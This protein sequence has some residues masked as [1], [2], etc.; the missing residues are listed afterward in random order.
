MGDRVS[1]GFQFLEDDVTGDPTGLRRARDG[2]TFPLAPVSGAWKRTEAVVKHIGSS[3]HTGVCF[4][5]VTGG[6]ANGGASALVLSITVKMEMETDFS[7]VRLV[8]IN[9]AQTA[10]NANIAVVGV[11]ETHAIDTSANMGTPVIG[12]TAYAQLAPAGTVSGWR[13]VT[14]GGASSVNVAAAPTAQQFA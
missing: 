4:N 1:T 10:I 5:Q 12:G 14:W 8:L 13:A 7:A 3:S 2:K 6:G 11:T 9:R